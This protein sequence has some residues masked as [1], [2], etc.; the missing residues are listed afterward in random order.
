MAST[1][2]PL[3]QAREPYP[4]EV[5][6]AGSA[7]IVRI[8]PASRQSF[9]GGEK[10]IRLGKMVRILQFLSPV[11]AGRDAWDKGIEQLLDVEHLDQTGVIIVT[12]L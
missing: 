3:P 1:G 5:T 8:Q 4:E 6:K 7:L 2:L 10:Y 9:T 11:D 12:N